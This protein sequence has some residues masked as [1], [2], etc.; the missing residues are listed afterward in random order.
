MQNKI[1]INQSIYDVCT[2]QEYQHQSENGVDYV[3][4]YTAIL[5]GDFVYPVLNSGN[6][7]GPGVMVGGPIS[8]FNKPKP[9]QEEQY[10]KENMI[11]FDDVKDMATM[12]DRLDAVK[13]LESEVLTSVD[14]I[15]APKIHPLD[16]PEMVA[17]KTAV[18]EKHIDLDKYE[19]RFGANY[20]ND[21]RLFNKHD[22]SIKMLKRV[23]SALDMNVSI[24]I[25]DVPD[26]PNPI[27]RDIEFDL[28]VNRQ[29]TLEE[30]DDETGEDDE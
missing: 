20:N 2:L 23:A 8:I 16:T 26:A 25:S 9:D 10:K 22:I 17:L 4:N 21:K 6:K 1:K 14:N 28:T 27:G 5:E 7:V 3:P 24:T 13:K 18:C 30:I 11:R 15:F 29:N 12:I 19:K